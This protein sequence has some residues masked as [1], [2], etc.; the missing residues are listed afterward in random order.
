MPRKRL[1]SKSRRNPE[2]KNRV[3]PVGTPMEGSPEAC[4][5]REVPYLGIQSP[6]KRKHLGSRFLS[7]RTTTKLGGEQRRNRDPCETAVGRQRHL[8]L[9][10][11]ACHYGSRPAASAALTKDLKSKQKEPHKQTSRGPNSSFLI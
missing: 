3:A 11:E 8:E 5:R 7:L 4:W 2:W 9:C 6:L 10:P 1:C